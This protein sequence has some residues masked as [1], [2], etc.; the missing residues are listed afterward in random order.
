MQ[1]PTKKVKS[2]KK[3]AEESA[4]DYCRLCN[5]VLKVKFG[6]FDKTSYV[7]SENL[8]NCSKTSKTDRTLQKL[9]C[10]LGF[11]IEKS[12]LTSDWV[13]KACARKIRNANERFHFIKAGLK[14]GKRIM[15]KTPREYIRVT[16][17]YIRVT[18]EYIRVTYKYIRVTYE[19]MQVTYEYILPEFCPNF[20]FLTIFLD[21]KGSNN[22]QR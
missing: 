16:Y 10:K 20:Y 8:F 4:R 18:Y 13:C 19:Y 21:E 7:S 6:N 17:K 15:I 12:S 5:C 11:L 9:C 14:H 22:T 3:V 2:G 1:T